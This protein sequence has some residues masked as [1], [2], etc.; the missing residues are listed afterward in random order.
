LWV[1]YPYPYHGADSGGVGPLS[2]WTLLDGQKVQLVDR[3]VTPF[4]SAEGALPKGVLAAAPAVLTVVLVIVLA[5]ELASL[6]WRVVGSS[7]SD[8]LPPPVVDVGAAPAV[9][10]ASIVNAHLFGVARISG[11]PNAAPATSANLVLAGTLAGVDPEQGWAI[12]G[13]DAQ[14]AHVYATGVTL[15]GGTRLVAVYPDR[16]ILDR[17]GVRE[18]LSLPRLSGAAGAAPVAYQPVGAQPGSLVDSVRELLSQNQTAVNDILRPQPVFAGG[19]LRGYRVYPGRSRGQFAKLGLQP[20]DLVTAVNGAALD[21]P[22]RALETLRGIGA[23]PAVTLTIDRN[24][25]Q[26]QLAVDPSAAVQELQRVAEPEPLSA[27]ESTE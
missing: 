27:P 17:N 20:G 6:L 24:G 11:D 3:I 9:D 23:G 25:Q 10:L 5:A 1:R 15:P 16:V 19:Q 26:Q 8:A 12:I 21:D 18:S 13:A 22:N 4:R 7:G 2:G 14:A